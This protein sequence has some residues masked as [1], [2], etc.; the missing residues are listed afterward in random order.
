[1]RDTICQFLDSETAVVL[2][3]LQDGGYGIIGRAFVENESSNSGSVAGYFSKEIGFEV[4]VV[5]L[6]QLTTATDSVLIMPG[7]PL[8][9]RQWWDEL[10]HAGQ[11]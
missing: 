1:M 5:S 8:T 2:R 6:Q 9:S 4:D 3:E 10:N 7:R 11:I